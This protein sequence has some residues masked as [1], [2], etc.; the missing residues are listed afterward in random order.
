[1][2]YNLP[3]CAYIHS[4]NIFE[5]KSQELLYQWD[6]QFLEKTEELLRKQAHSDQPICA[7]NLLGNIV[8]CFDRT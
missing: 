4:R 8:S 2:A 3:V 6:L 1:M 7:Q 5:G